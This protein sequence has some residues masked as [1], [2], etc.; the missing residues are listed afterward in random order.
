MNYLVHLSISYPFPDYVPGNFIFD[1]LPRQNKN[2]PLAILQKGIQLHKQ[3]DHYSNNHPSLQEIN[4]SLHPFVHK[5][6][7]VASDI[8]CDYLLY[9][10]WVPNIST[11]FD[12]F[13]NWNY[14]ILMEC[15]DVFPEKLQTSTRMMIEHKWLYQYTSINGL[16]NVLTRM[17][18]KLRFEGD[19]TK[20]LEPLSKNEKYYLELFQSFYTDLRE[21][22][23]LWIIPQSEMKL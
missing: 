20:V 13:A 3:I 6:A 15:L 1:L 4:K 9:R 10:L 2:K 14:K 5:Y 8:I 21:L 23:N 11:E 16:L 7:P 12:E 19:L 17:N 18:S 22:S